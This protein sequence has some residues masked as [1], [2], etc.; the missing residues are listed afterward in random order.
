M[1]MKTLIKTVNGNKIWRYWNA[2]CRRFTYMI[3][4]GGHEVIQENTLAE[5]EATA[6]TFNG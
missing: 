6:A 5:A 2:L 4:R 3:T 1:T